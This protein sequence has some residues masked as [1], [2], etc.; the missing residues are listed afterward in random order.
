MGYFTLF[1]LIQIKRE[2]PQ[3]HKSERYGICGKSSTKCVSGQACY[4]SCG[5]QSLL[6]MQLQC[7]HLGYR[8]STAH[9]SMPTPQP[10]QPPWDQGTFIQWKRGTVAQA[11]CYQGPTAKLRVMGHSGSNI[12]WMAG[13]KTKC[14]NAIGRL[15]VVSYRRSAVDTGSHPPLAEQDKRALFWEA[16]GPVG[17]KDA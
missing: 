4:V 13:G 15:K 1:G 9:H 14:R 16:E 5:E 2:N 10:K 12:T 3:T 8:L 6:W 7:L 17:L 11:H